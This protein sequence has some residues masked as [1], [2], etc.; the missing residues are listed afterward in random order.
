MKSIRII[1]LVLAAG[2]L[3]VGC[4]TEKKS[5]NK[6]ATAKKVEKPGIHW[7]KNVDGVTYEQV[8][9]LA[10]KENKKIFLDF[11]TK[12]CGPC[13]S[14]DQE[15][16][17]QKAIGDFYNDK[18]I[19][20]KIDAEVGEGIELAKQY[21]VT[22]YPTYVYVDVTGKPL[23]EAGSHIGRGDVEGM[24]E[25][26]KEALG[27]KVKSWEEYQAEYKASDKKDPVF[28][29]Q[30]MKARL[31]FTRMPPSDTLKLQWIKALPQATLFKNKDA[32]NTI[33]WNAV[34]GNEF[35]TMM[36]AN[37]SEYPELNNKKEAVVFLGGALLRSALGWDTKISYAKVK[38]AYLKD[39]PKYAQT[40]ID[41]V[42]I[43]K[44]RFNP[45]T[46]EKYVD[47]YFTFVEKEGL[48]LN[49]NPF[50]TG[51]LTGTAKVNPKYA[52][53]AAPL[54]DEGVNSEPPHFYSVA[55]KT[56]LLAKGGKMKEAQALANRFK[57]LTESFNGNKKM[58]WA[59]ATMKSVEA[60]KMP[61]HMKR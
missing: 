2:M 3:T 13:R 22:G 53:K 5:D 39:F 52:L 14:M 58:K 55:T 4:K 7:Q 38:A 45:K 26:A 9:A 31:K 61:E 35:Y 24:I 37:K 8:K 30:Y 46:S 18:F 6:T 60:G 50:I 11:Y 16:F 34:P 40:A 21:E 17:S 1:A 44:L 32:K 47:A 15:V 51:S 57:D 29:Q 12:W 33:K 19:N 59:Y 42:N 27:G 48:P 20:F 49:M 41:Y 56:Y 36:V 54:L 10:K 43:D 28:L 25:F 23:I